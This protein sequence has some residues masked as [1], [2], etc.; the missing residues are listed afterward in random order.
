MGRWMLVAVLAIALAGCSTPSGAAGTLRGTVT[1]GPL[2]PVQREGAPTPTVAPQV[3]TSRGLIISNEDGTREVGRVQ[4]TADGT[5]RLS[6]PPGRYRVELQPNGI[7]R[8]DGL[9]TVVAIESGQVT[10]L[11]V[12]IDT[13]IR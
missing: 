10:P 1:V 5:Y 3:Y 11:D 13:G 6:L 8:A 9:P 12:N 7:D 4:F 2:M